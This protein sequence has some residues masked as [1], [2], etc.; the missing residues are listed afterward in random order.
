MTDV[1]SATSYEDFR[2]SGRA[3]RRNAI[4]GIL[5]SPGDLEGSELSEALAEVNI[6][7]AGKWS[8]GGFLALLYIVS[9]SGVAF[10]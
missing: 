8:F 7:K 9:C 4:H 10:W 2:A 3:G 1:E 6:S 5:G